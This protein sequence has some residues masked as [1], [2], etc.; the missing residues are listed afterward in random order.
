MLEV[1]DFWLKYVCRHPQ[2]GILRRGIRG[3]RICVGGFGTWPA[4]RNVYIFALVD[5]FH[6]IELLLIII[7]EKSEDYFTVLADW[8]TTHQYVFFILF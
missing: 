3:W 6:Y 5:N 8:S 7:G 2:F 1:V 4:R